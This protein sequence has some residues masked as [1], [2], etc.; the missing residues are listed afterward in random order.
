VV[1]ETYIGLAPLGISCA[2]IVNECPNIAVIQILIKS[3][4]SAGI[5]LEFNF[6]PLPITALLNNLRAPYN[7]SSPTPAIASAALPPSNLEYMRCDLDSILRLRE[8]MLEALP[9]IKSSA[10]SRGCGIKLCAVEMLDPN[11][12]TPSNDVAFKVCKGL[13]S[14]RLIVVRFRGK[15]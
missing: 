10:D 3:F 12:Q 9:K 13:A 7:V 2:G 4:G 15:A 11:T 14:K 6:A 5:R 8:R 1:N